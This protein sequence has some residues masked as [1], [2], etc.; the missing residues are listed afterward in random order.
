MLHPMLAQRASWSVVK[1][2]HWETSTQ[3]HKQANILHFYNTPPCNTHTHLL[4]LLF[5]HNISHSNCHLKSLTLSLSS[6]HCASRLPAACLLLRTEV[7]HTLLLSLPFPD[8][9]CC[10]VGLLIWMCKCASLG[11]HF[12]A[13]NTRFTLHNQWK[14]S[15]DIADVQ[16]VR[17]KTMASYT[18]S[19]YIV[20]VAH[21]MLY[22]FY[23]TLY[24][25]ICIL[26][27][28]FS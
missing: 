26:M 28:L 14:H 2:M 1:I 12:T 27:S 25:F 9:N 22:V 21:V 13:N 19:I 8:W 20:R 5:C 10:L 23:T 4:L 15:R 24:I 17:V 16:S 18:T 6:A 11:Y 3:L 7:P